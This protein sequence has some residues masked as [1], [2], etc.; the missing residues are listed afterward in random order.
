MYSIKFIVNLFAFLSAFIAFLSVFK[1]INPLFLII[2]FILFITGIF[3]EKKAIFPI[4]RVFLNIFSVL[5]V[6]FS[7]FRVSLDNMVLPV[8]EAL[9]ILLGVKLIENKEFRD[10]MQIFTISV[11]LLAGSAL[12]SINIVFLLYFL[13][14]FFIISTGIIFLTFYSQDKNLVLSKKETLSIFLKTLF[15]PLIAIPSTVFL[16]VILPRTDYPL[17]NFLNKSQT[18]VVGFSD[19]VSLGD[20]SEIQEDNSVAFRVQMEKTNPENLYFRGVV[21]DYFDG[22]SWK[23]VNRKVLRERVIFS[24]NIIKQTIFLNPYGKNYLFGLNYPLKVVGRN[25]VIYD[26][27][28]LESKKPINKTI[29]YTIYSKLSPNIPS[30]FINKNVYLQLPNLS[31]KVVKFAK[32]LKGDKTVP[33]FANFLINY[34]NKNYKYSMEN[35]PYGENALEDFLFDKKAGNCE[36]FASAAAVILRINNI[37][38]RVVAG[39]KGANY[40]NIA[41]YYVVFNKNAHTWVEYYYNG[42][43]Y[44]LDPTPALRQSILKKK[45]LSLLFKLR[46]LLDTINY[47]Y[48]NFVIDFDFKK[49]VKVFKYFS[50]SLE[51]LKESLYLI[52]KT[53]LNNLLVIITAFFIAFFSIK[54]IRYYSI[55]FEERI[56][57]EFYRNMEKYGYIKKENEGL[58][59]FIE[60][61]NNKDLKVK[62]KEFADIFESFYYKDRKFTKKDKKILKDIL[63]QI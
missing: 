23:R 61:I 33:E 54:I 6:L 53:V 60:K 9:I 45:E 29:K 57:N 4:P 41:K 55:P 44:L 24:R 26:D 7:I 30:H 51:S 22:R 42:Y 36:F 63:R 49:Q 20:V 17:F 11:F 38:A 50:N 27:Y 56:L 58:I 10:Y 48:I 28:V 1:Y 15:I 35:L 19:N 43:W 32:N 2:F 34:F 40:N 16:F 21:L 31:K 52:A 59:E 14:L 25:A 3:F 62:A 18:A 39:Y 46:L 47:Y 37:P 5:V 8:V 13:L 12:L